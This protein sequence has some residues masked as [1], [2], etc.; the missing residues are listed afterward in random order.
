M[1]NELLDSRQNKKGLPVCLPQ[2]HVDI[3]VLHLAQEK[4][5]ILYLQRKDV[6]VVLPGIGYSLCGL[7]L[8]VWI[9]TMW[10]QSFALATSL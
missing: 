6:S 8:F 1:R 7:A 4:T 3:K 2:W 10:A 9:L 5:L